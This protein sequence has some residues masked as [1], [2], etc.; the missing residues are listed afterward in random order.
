[1]PKIAVENL[2]FYYGEK[3]ALSD[4]TMDVRERQITALIG[5]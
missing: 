4:I 3:R 2:S 5:P 1:M